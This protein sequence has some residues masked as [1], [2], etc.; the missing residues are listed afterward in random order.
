MAGETNTDKIAKL[1]DRTASLLARLG[2][3][4][5]LIKELTERSKKSTDTNEGHG[6]RITRRATDSCCCGA[7]RCGSGDRLHQRGTR[8]HQE[9]HREPS[10]LESR[11]EE[12]EG[13]SR[14]TLVVIRS[15]HHRCPYRRLH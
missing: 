7:E 11:A 1:E 6:S 9:G 8:R 4:E 2:V 13:G 5:T 3:V 10:K 14:T 12:G 15:E